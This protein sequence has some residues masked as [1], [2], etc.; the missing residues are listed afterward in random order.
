MFQVDGKMH[1]IQQILIP[2]LIFDTL[3]ENIVLKNL[4]RII[5]GFILKN[6]QIYLIWIVGVWGKINTK[7]TFTKQQMRVEIIF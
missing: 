1:S 6:L 4:T 3:D 7:E 2:S 5:E